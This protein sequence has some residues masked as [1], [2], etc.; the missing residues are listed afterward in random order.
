MNTNNNL[1]KILVSCAVVLVVAVL[2]CS[3]GLTLGF[4][5]GHARGG[6]AIAAAPTL[7]AR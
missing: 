3:A 5:V 7:I 4:V 2:V 1:L 6:Q